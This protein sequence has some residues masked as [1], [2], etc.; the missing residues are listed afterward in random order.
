LEGA[1]A[2]NASEMNRTGP[3]DVDAGDAGRKESA[4]T[5]LSLRRDGIFTPKPSR[6]SIT[7]S[8]A[9]PPPTGWILLDV[10]Y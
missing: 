1:E 10:G 5:P 2:L 6:D 7:G 3:P 8:K 4:P 9:T